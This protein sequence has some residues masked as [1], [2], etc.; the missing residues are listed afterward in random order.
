MPVLNVLHRRPTTKRL[1]AM[2]KT[3]KAKASHV[4]TSQQQVTFDTLFHESKHQQYTAIKDARFSLLGLALMAI[5]FIG[6]AGTISN[7]V[8]SAIRRA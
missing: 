8:I 7:I 2:I 4:L 6:R 3:V 1:V 5:D